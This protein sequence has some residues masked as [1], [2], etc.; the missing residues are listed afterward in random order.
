[1]PIF[2]VAANCDEVRSV[3]SPTRRLLAISTRST[4]ARGRARRAAAKANRLRTG[5]PNSSPVASVS[6]VGGGLESNRSHKSGPLLSSIWCKRDWNLARA[7]ASITGYRGRVPGDSAA[8]FFG[9]QARRRPEQFFDN[10]SWRADAGG[11]T[12]NTATRAREVFE[13]RANGGWN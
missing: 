4:C 3:M 11:L 6:F 2:F 9:F 10:G 13:F 8:S 5:S 12:E 7:F 1:M